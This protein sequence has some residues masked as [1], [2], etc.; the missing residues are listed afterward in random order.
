MVEQRREKTDLEGNLVAIVEGWFSDAQIYGHKDMLVSMS[1]RGWVPL[2][3][4][5]SKL[6]ELIGVVD[7]ARVADKLRQSLLLEVDPERRLVRR[8]A[9]LP[10]GSKEH[11][12]MVLLDIPDV[13][14]SIRQMPAYLQ[15]DGATA[16]YFDYAIHAAIISL[17]SRHEAVQL[18][19]DVRQS[20]KMK[21][22]LLG[23]AFPLVG[24]F[25]EEVEEVLRAVDL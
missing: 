3:V 19:N 18:V 6:E 20:G 7:G 23:E 17:Q 1:G 8:L 11:R 14:K 12:Q 25:D 10:A 15:I 5:E 21:A 13:V 4:V 24:R 22:K 16:D 9:A 2:A